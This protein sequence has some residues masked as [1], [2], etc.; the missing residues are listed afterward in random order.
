MKI[1]TANAR[2]NMEKLEQVLQE[3]LNRLFAEA[4]QKAIQF[5]IIREGDTITISQPEMY[6]QYLFKLTGI[7]NELHIAKSEHY[8]DDVNLLT[9]QSLLETLES[10]V[11]DGAEIIYISGE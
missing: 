8:V 1:I 11:L 7:G 5:L 9:L 4:R 10:D 3:K 2:W 6:E